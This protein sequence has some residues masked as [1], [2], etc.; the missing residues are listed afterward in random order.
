MNRLVQVW[1]ARLA[2]MGNWVSAAIS[3]AATAWRLDNWET[4][5]GQAIALI[6]VLGSYVGAQYLRV[7]RPRRRGQRA[8][9]LAQQPP[10]QPTDTAVVA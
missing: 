5:I 8:A 9:Q 1:S 6:L 4:F 2:V 3:G 10:P 7:W